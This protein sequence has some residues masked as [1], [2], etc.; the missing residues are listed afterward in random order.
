MN[1]VTK[2]ALIVTVTNLVV[3]ALLVVFTINF[4]D[5][6]DVA[7]VLLLFFPLLMLVLELIVGIVYAV[8]ESKKDIGAGLLIG[9]GLTLLI[10]LSVCGVMANS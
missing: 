9:C 10:G 2:Y 4:G 6:L 1:K 3:F 5:E 7:L 8:G